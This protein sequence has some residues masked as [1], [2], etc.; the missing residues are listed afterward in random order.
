MEVLNVHFSIFDF[1]ALWHLLTGPKTK[2]FK[3]FFLFLESVPRIFTLQIE[4]EDWNLVHK[5]TRNYG[6]NFR[7]VSAILTDIYLHFY[8]W[9]RKN[10][11]ERSFLI[12]FFMSYCQWK[13]G[14]C[15]SST[16]GGWGGRGLYTNS[17]GDP[18]RPL[19]PF[20]GMSDIYLYFIFYFT[21]PLPSE[22]PKNKIIYSIR[23][24]LKTL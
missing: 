16:F 22:G 20:L 4:L 5:L 11:V 9:S 7:W 14:Y 13:P 17:V 8:C 2:F 3:Q 23:Y 15:S 19:R 24:W 12:W 10:I 21:S 6:R 1:W 18:N